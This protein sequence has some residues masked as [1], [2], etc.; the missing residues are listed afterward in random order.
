MPAP[1]WTPWGKGFKGRRS[2]FD[3][4]RMQIRKAG[5]KVT[6]FTRNGHSWTD[7]FRRLA[8]E[9]AAWPTCIIDAELVATDASGVADFATL[10]RTVTKRQEDGP[11][12]LGVR[13]ALRA[14]QGYPPIPYIERKKRLA[15][16]LARADIGALRHL[17]FFTD[18]DRLLAAHGM[19]GLE[20]IA[21]KRRDCAYCSGK[22]LSWVKCKSEAWRKAN[23]ER[24]KLFDRG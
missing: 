24:H 15:N 6:I 8:A 11:R 1:L 18:G 2:P 14:R 19:G 10:Q 21:S 23:R 5:R 16:L 20:G 3:G 17:E 7:H 13:P 22:R 9:L 12:I 4:Y